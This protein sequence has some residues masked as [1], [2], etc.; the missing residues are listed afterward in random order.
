MLSINGKE[1]RRCLFCHKE[2]N[3]EHCDKV[4]ECSECKK[5][6]FKSARCFSCLIL[7]HRSSQRR[8]CRSKGHHSIDL[9]QI[10]NHAIGHRLKTQRR[11]CRGKGHHASI[12]TSFMPPK[13]TRS[14]P[15]APQLDPSGNALVECTGFYAAVALPTTWKSLCG[16]EEGRVRVVFDAGSHRVFIAAK[17]VGR[18]WLEIARKER[19]GIEAFERN[20]TRVESKNVLELT[21]KD[22]RGVGEGGKSQNLCC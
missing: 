12:Y 22:L 15:T 14:E 11:L 17:P 6:L 10:E 16:K 9:K 13:K 5:L 7:G 20:N 1:G 19:L 18:L 3:A 21:L 2:C 4:R 8:L